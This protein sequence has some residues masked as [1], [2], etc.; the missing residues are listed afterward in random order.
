MNEFDLI[1]TFFREKSRLTN[2]NKIFKNKSFIGIGDDA[3]VFSPPKGF[4]LVVSSDLLIEGTH[5]RR[6][7]TPESI[8]HKV[9]AVNLSDI[10]A[11]GAEPLCF[12]LSISIQSIDEAWLCKFCDG[13]FDLA[14]E[15]SCKLIGG[16]TVRSK[17][18]APM[19]FGVT[20]IG[21]V[22]SG[23]ALKRKSMELND[24][25]WVSGSLGDPTEAL[26]NNFFCKKLFTPQ[27]RLAL[28]KELLDF[29]NSAIDISD[30]LSSD[31]LHLL[32]ESSKNLKRK[33]IATIDFLSIASCLGPYLFSCY[34]KNKLTLNECC[35]LAVASGDEYE[36]CF[37]ARKE[38]RK[39]IKSLSADLDLPLT[40]IGEVISEK[41]SQE[42]FGFNI[43]QNI[44]WLDSKGLPIDLK[45]CPSSG[46]SHF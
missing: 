4:D 32:G 44:I 5:F 36:L 43:K 9:L 2:S 8:G 25:I 1:E 27:P 20:V 16:D 19:F 40:R 41:E 29:A 14:N 13:I 18:N 7:H 38:F 45:N 37:S 39:T 23:K 31:L 34:L 35:S 6:D 33:V 42:I 11:M 30:G 46:F 10:A 22:P 15:F 12:T 21:I 24:D 17:E 3:S 28:G 26:K